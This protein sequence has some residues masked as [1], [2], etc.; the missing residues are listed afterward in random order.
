[1]EKNSDART[2]LASLYFRSGKYEDATREYLKVL[3][4]LVYKHQYRVYYGLALI[5]LERKRP[6]E[7]RKYLQKSIE[8]K[9]DYCAA[10][11]KLGELAKEAYHYNEAYKR[12]K[13][14]SQGTCFQE[15]RPHYEQALTLM[16][17]RDFKK[18]HAKLKEIIE[19]FPKS[20]YSEMATKEIKKIKKSILSRSKFNKNS[21]FRSPS[22]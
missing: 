18:A 20:S 5:S 12:F 17:M 3:E 7:A 14:A 21:N 13:L 11:F 6:L 1:N 2:N 10:H 19:M 4:D 9:E 15:P 16:Q 22:F 8:E